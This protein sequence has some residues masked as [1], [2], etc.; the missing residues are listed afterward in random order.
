[1]RFE[2]GRSAETGV[3][4]IRR[5]T[6]TGHELVSFLLNRFPAMRDVIC[7]DQDCFEEP[8]RAYDSFAATVINMVDDPKFIKSVGE[9]IDDAIAKRDPLLRDV[10]IADLLEGIAVD[11]EAARKLSDVVSENARMLLR[12]VE[13]NI[14]GRER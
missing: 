2:D 1:M 3:N 5:T 11:P 6:M 8:T 7:P 4:F 13:R 12:N 9:F 14:Y 10:L